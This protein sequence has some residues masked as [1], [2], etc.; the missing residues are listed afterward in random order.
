MD[1]MSF[2]KP[3]LI[4][5]HSFNTIK[6]VLIIKNFTVVYILKTR[7]MSSPFI[8][9]LITEKPTL[10]LSL[11]QQYVTL[12]AS[13]ISTRKIFIFLAPF[14]E[15]EFLLAQYLFWIWMKLK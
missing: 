8:T 14:N 13:W 10:K 2:F 7:I 4:I 11:P 1:A 12:F 15:H 3:H 5:K 9:T 6:K